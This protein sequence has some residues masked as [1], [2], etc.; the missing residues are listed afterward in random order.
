MNKKAFTLLEL[1]MVVII[2]GILATIAVPQYEK[3]KEKA[4]AAE[5]VRMMGAIKR[6]QFRYK[7]EHG[8]YATVNNLGESD[9]LG[10]DFRVH[11]SLR[12]QDAYWTYGTVGGAGPRTGKLFINAYREYKN[13]LPH[14]WLEGTTIELIWDDDTGVTW[15]GNHP[16]VPKN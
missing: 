4:I 5:A 7:A 15:E 12:D 3:F 14:G 8:E 1:L 10:M 16:G 11:S 9:I 13:R 2:I 6:A